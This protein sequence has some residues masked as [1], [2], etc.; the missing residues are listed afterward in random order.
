MSKLENFMPERR[1][2]GGSGCHIITDRA[3]T[4]METK[5]TRLRHTNEQLHQHRAHKPY[6]SVS[7]GPSYGGGQT[8]PCSLKNNKSNTR[9]TDELLTNK[10]FQHLI[11]FGNFSFFIFAPSSSCTYFQTQMALLRD[12]IHWSGT[13]PSLS[14]PHAPFTS[15][16]TP[17]LSPTLIYSNLFRIF[18]NFFAWPLTV[19]LK[20][21]AWLSFRPK[22]RKTPYRGSN[23]DA[24][25]KTSSRNQEDE[26]KIKLERENCWERDTDNRE[27]AAAALMS[28]IWFHGILGPLQATSQ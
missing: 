1:V 27:R 9:V 24:K 15:D 8:E 20:P 6:P 7:R 18:M 5:A 19:K 10:S 13:R 22:C 21:E 14:S 23:S 3:A 4:L 2:L 26:E 11:R 28:K 17:S 25:P 12:Q 16:P